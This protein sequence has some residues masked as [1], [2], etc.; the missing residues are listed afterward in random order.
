[1]LRE[2]S[3]QNSSNFRR[4][5]YQTNRDSIKFS[6]KGHPHIKITNIR[7]AHANESVQKDFMKTFKKE[8]SH[9]PQ[10]VTMA[11]NQ[12]ILEAFFNMDF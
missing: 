9:S 7:L 5:F 1:M 11:Q 3:K 6:L 12:I 10:L 4:Q 8:S 2:A